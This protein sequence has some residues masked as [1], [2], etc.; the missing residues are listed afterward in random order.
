MN[1]LI[2]PQHRGS[3]CP[4]H[5]IPTH[6]RL[7]RYHQAPSSRPPL[8]PRWLRVSQDRRFWGDR[9]GFMCPIEWMEMRSEAT[10][11]SEQGVRERRLL[12]WVLLRS[13]ALRQRV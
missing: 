4:P 9:A 8:H 5:P 2:P 12:P 6:P 1:P 3:L 7:R 13:P 11:G 10:A